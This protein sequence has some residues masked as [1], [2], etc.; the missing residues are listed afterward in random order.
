MRSLIQPSN[1]SVILVLAIMA[2]SCGGS[3]PSTNNDVDADVGSA[4]TAADEGNTVICLNGTVLEECSSGQVCC[5]EGSYYSWGFVG[6][7]EA[8]AC[9][10]SSCRSCSLPK[11]CCVLAGSE[12]QLKIGC[13][14]P[15]ECCNC[16]YAGGCDS[17]DGIS[18]VCCRSQYSDE[19]AC[20]PIEE[21][22]TKP[23]CGRPYCSHSNDC[24]GSDVCCAVSPGGCGTCGGVCVSAGTCAGSGFGTCK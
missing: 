9:A 17:C 16:G 19:F 18:T 1:V 3:V 4:D 2:V 12:E 22:G 8:T 23:S 5:A 20:V 14:S 24:S 21:C 15:N 10:G 6:C 7:K 13:V 11:V